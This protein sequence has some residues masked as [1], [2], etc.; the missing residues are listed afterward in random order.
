MQQTN[1]I[2]RYGN[3]ALLLF[4]SDF[5]HKILKGQRLF[6]VTSHIVLLDGGGMILSVVL[7]VDRQRLPGQREL[8]QATPHVG[9]ESADIHSFRSSCISI[10]AVGKNVKTFRKFSGGRK[11]GRKEV[12]LNFTRSSVFQR[13]SGPSAS[14]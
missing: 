9:L 11:E 5:G 3:F 7:V 4:A 10:V 14:H 1:K 8:V 12:S 6:V 13:L 2:I